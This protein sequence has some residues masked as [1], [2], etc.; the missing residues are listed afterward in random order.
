MIPEEFRDERNKRWDEP[1][2]DEPLDGETVAR[3]LALPPF[4]DVRAEDFPAWLPLDQIIAN[5]GRLRRYGRGEIIIRKGDYG[6]SLFAILEGEVVGLASR[7][8]EDSIVVGTPRSRKSWWRSLA[9]LLARKHA[10]EYRPARL[11]LVKGRSPVS[12][13]GQPDGLGTVDIDDLGSRY[14]T[15]AMQPPQMFGELAALTRS[16]RSTSIFAADDSTLLFE[17]RWQG[18][19]DIR[20]WSAP[21]RQQID[22]LYRERGLV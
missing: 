9:R 16:P 12:P 6:D 20:S 19:R 11:R 15:F 8:N 22:A 14:P 4:A 5:D 2:S 13:Q 21:F 3:I 18:L 10:P 17:L 7:A 1:Y